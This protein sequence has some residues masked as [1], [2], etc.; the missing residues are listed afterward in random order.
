[1]FNDKVLHMVTTQDD[2]DMFQKALIDLKMF[3]VAQDPLEGYFMPTRIWAS[4]SS[5]NYMS[6]PY[7]YD[8]QY[9]FTFNSFWR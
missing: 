1:L 7:D 2:Y 4:S 5:F 9:S 6:Y 3:I 8:R